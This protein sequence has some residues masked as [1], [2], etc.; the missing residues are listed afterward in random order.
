[1]LAFVGAAPEPAERAIR[2]SRVHVLARCRVGARCPPRARKRSAG[3][4]IERRWAQV[5]I[6]LHCRGVLQGFAQ[7]GAVCV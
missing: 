4:G 7:V 5:P 6:T 1:M 2:Q 3:L